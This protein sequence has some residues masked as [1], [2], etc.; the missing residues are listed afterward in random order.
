MQ[1]DIPR[2][3]LRAKTRKKG[4]AWGSTFTASL[5]VGRLGGFSHLRILQ[6]WANQSTRFKVFAVYVSYVPSLLSLKQ[7]PHSPPV[8][9]R[10]PICWGIALSSF[11]RAHP[12]GSPASL[13]G[14]RENH[15]P[16]G[17]RRDS[18]H[19]GASAEALSSS[20]RSC[21]HWCTKDLSKKS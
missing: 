15:K 9:C 5:A 19:P 3:K 16:K 1:P 17:C 20:G 4:Q 14:C 18:G 2:C 10:Y 7:P 12:Q 13:K 21:K 11:P 6:V 8:I